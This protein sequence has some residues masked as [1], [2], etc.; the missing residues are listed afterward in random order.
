MV[1]S[2]LSQGWQ[3]TQGWHG[4]LSF[5]SYRTRLGSVGL[6]WPAEDVRDRHDTLQIRDT[7][8]PLLPGS[9]V[10]LCSESCFGHQTSN[11]KRFKA[12]AWQA[13]GRSDCCKVCFRPIHPRLAYERTLGCVRMHATCDASQPPPSLTRCMAGEIALC[14][15]LRPPLLRFVFLVTVLCFS[16]RWQGRNLTVAR[17]PGLHFGIPRIDKTKVGPCM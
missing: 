4:R 17:R 7:S 3:K 5:D 14:A 13:G 2:A 8:R 12:V 6:A 9:D 1:E 15:S 10:N 16:I 11:A